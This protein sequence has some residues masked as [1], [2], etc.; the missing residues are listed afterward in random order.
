MTRSTFHLTARPPREARLAVFARPPPWAHVLALAAALFA[1][2]AR[3]GPVETINADAAKAPIV[4]QPLRS[5]LFVLSGSGGNITVLVRGGDALLVD[6]GIAVSRDRIRDALSAVGAKRLK[7]LFDTH[8]HWD[9]TDG[10][11]WIRAEGATIQASQVTLEHLG[12]DTTVPEWEHTF[13]RSPQAARPTV[14][15]RDGQTVTFRGERIR[16]LAPGDS[17]TDSD[18]F[19]RFED[20]DVVALGDL[21][22][23]GVYPFIDTHNGGSIDGA[24][25]AA[26]LALRHVSE[27]TIV[28]SGHGPV[29]DRSDLV[30]FRDMLVTARAAI[31]ALKAQGLSVEEVVARQPTRDLDPV[32]GKFVVTPALFTRLVYTSLP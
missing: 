29:G 21:F 8:Y 7:V 5:G 14:V 18:L 17:H 15:L 28:V 26:N 9:H 32:W 20:A 1:G 19:F 13:P 24:I 4:T 27:R 12:R 25:A 30:R 22:W 10:N 23:N 31:A 3:G 2:I 16:V 11:E 6:G